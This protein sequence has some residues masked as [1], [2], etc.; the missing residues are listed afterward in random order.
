VSYERCPAVRDTNNSS[1]DFAAHNTPGEQTPGIACVGLPGVDMQID[2]TGP[3][4]VHPGDPVQFTISYAN[5]GDTNELATTVTITDTL[6]AGLAFTPSAGNAVPEPTTISGNKLIWVVPAPLLGGALS[7]IALTTTADVGLAENVPLINTA[8]IASTNEQAIRKTNNTTAWTTTTL[9]PADTSISSNLSGPV[10]PGAQFQF[11]ITYQNTGQDDATDV[12]ITDVL[13]AG[14]TILSVDSPDATWDNATTGTVTWDV[15]ALPANGES[16]TIVVTARL[17]SST[18]A[19]TTLT[20]L[21]SITAPANDPT[22]TNN[23]ETTALTVGLRKLYLALIA[24]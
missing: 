9:G 15:G 4:S 17:A 6:P 3:S 13:P 8:E 21:L 2:K 11:T 7:T 23:V 5:V 14:V 1:V 22:P 16:H 10:P 19:G 18:A 20:N 24:R 12:T